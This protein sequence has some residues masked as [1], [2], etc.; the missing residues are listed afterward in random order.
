MESVDDE[1]GDHSW[2]G[3]EVRESDQYRTWTILISRL[4]EAGWVMHA[5][6]KSIL[7]IYLIFTKYMYCIMYIVYIHLLLD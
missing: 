5:I 3:A 7:E 1:V 2:G 4:R 6:N